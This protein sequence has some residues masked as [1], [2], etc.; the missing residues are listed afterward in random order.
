MWDRRI[1]RRLQIVMGVT[2]GLV[3]TVTLW[4][5]YR[6]SRQQLI[7]GTVLRSQEAVHS[8]VGRLDD[9]LTR[10]GQIPILIAARQAILGQ[11]PDP[12]M[13]DYL[14]TLLK[15]L[16][17]VDPYGVYIA[18]DG[19]AWNAPGAMPWVD[20]NGE[21][22][23]QYD[24]HLPEYEWYHETR[25]R[26]VLHI[27]EPYFDEGGSNVEMVSVNFPA[28]DEEGRLIGIAGAD[29]HLERIREIVRTMETVFERES[30]VRSEAAI[31]AFLISR[32]GK[33]IAA[34][35]DRGKQPPKTL[36]DIPGMPLM[37][38][39]KGSSTLELNGEQYRL[40]W[41]TSA[42]TGWRLVLRISE[43]AVMGPVHELGLQ[44]ATVAVVGL[45]ILL[46]LLSWVSR[47]LTRPIEQLTVCAAEFAQGEYGTDGL[48]AIVERRDELGELA[49]S[50][51]TMSSEILS[52]E[53]RLVDWNRN[54]KQMVEDRTQDLELTA[55]RAE[56]ARQDAEAANRTKSVFL[57]NMSHE[58]RT[59]M[60]AIIGYSEMLMEDMQDA[61]NTAAEADLKKIHGAG[62]HLLGL[63]N[64]ILDLSRIEAGRMTVYCEPFQVRDLVQDVQQTI[65]PLVSRNQNQLHLQIAADA[66]QMHSDLT[67]VRQILLNLLSNACKFSDH[68]QI[69]LTVQR[70]ADWVEFEVTDSG[71]GMTEEQISRLFQ[72]FSQADVSTTR[73]Y[74]GTGLGLAISRHFSELL[75]GRIDVLST[76]GKGSTFTVRLPAV[77]SE[78]PPTEAVSD[79]SPSP[80]IQ[81][82][83]ESAAESSERPLVIVID[84]DPAVLDLMQR[85][86]AREGYAVRT[87]DNGREGLELARTLHP[88]LVTVDV[89]M[90]GMD[91][92]S[93]L[94]ALKTDSSTADIPVIMVT[95]DGNRELGMAL[96][97][98]DY[99][100]KPLDW[101]RLFR[102]LQHMQLVQNRDQILLVEDDAATQ[103][104]IARKLRESGWTVAIAGNGLEALHTLDNFSPAVVL[105]DLMMPQMDGFQFL[106][107]FRRQERFRKTPVVVLTAMELNQADRELL[108]DQ[109]LL[110]LQKA[111]IGLDELQGQLQQ[112][113]RK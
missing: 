51:Q 104:L 13:K 106:A 83:T 84:D 14:R 95:M 81:H 24:Y 1:G 57:A 22:I 105:L 7:R 37:D 94:N 82:G 56:Q 107:E 41:V 103:E 65:Q 58:L 54:L 112:L 42:M 86:L 16:D 44:S 76:V 10:I 75:G 61:G 4:L 89:M 12:L 91:G 32:Q 78:Q 62:K 108:N 36:E 70:I 2:A 46:V 26:R 30:G 48:R 8:A 71:I 72:A 31:D 111:G 40:V 52:R 50:F 43:R 68:G 27:S 69:R 15:A 17:D 18:Y 29:L 53:K 6:S 34:P 90:P 9:F 98:L 20:R 67:K 79:A 73:K 80:A 63:I 3:L 25:Q 39:D 96:G 87:A 66:G 33:V 97:A 93:V 11:S 49:R 59:P 28:L 74:G 55:R 23:V 38:S 92:W 85:F 5:N 109:V 35:S 47:K 45:G 110:V 113:F 21:P 64:D 99:L 60:N 100:S 102:H 101:P 77:V 19:L 88:L